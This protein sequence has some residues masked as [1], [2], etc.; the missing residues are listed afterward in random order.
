LID[1]WFHDGRLL[2]WSF[3]SEWQLNKAGAV[4]KRAQDRRA[5]EDRRLERAGGDAGEGQG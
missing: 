1:T 5:G 2:N 3:I 4:E